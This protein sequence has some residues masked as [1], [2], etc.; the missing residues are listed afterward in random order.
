MDAKSLVDE[1]AHKFVQFRRG[2]GCGCDV[3]ELIGGF[4][5][6]EAIAAIAKLAT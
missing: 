4:H 3:F 6:S 1:V 5:T 2:C